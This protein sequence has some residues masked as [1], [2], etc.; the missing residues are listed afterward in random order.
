MPEVRCDRRIEPARFPV[1]FQ[2]LAFGLGAFASSGYDLLGSGLL[3]AELIA[4][5]TEIGEGPTPGRA[6][7]GQEQWR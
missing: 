5:R 1:G 4:H 2:A 6:N 7:C 3:A